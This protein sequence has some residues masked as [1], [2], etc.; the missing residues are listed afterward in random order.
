MTWPRVPADDSGSSVGKGG[1]PGAGRICERRFG[2]S[3]AATA[4]SRAFPVLRLPTGA[5]ED[6]ADPGT[7][8][9]T[10]LAP[11]GAGRSSLGRDA[12]TRL[13]RS[14]KLRPP[15]SRRGRPTSH[16]WPGG[17][18]GGPAGSG[19]GGSGG[20]GSR[21]QRHHRT[22]RAHRCHEWTERRTGLD[23]PYLHEWSRGWWRRRWRARWDRRRRWI[24][25]GGLPQHQSGRFPDRHAPECGYRQ[26]R[27]DATWPFVAANRKVARRGERCRASFTLR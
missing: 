18:G 15:G 12:G 21:H 11:V 19:R 14:R 10:V 13:G 6:L 7:A 1:A 20:G 27:R 8:R 4:A 23:E 24:G 9:S 5:P 22:G 25:R 26:R 2:W 16:A 17:A 3:L